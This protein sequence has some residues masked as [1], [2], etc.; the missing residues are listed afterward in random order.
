MKHS[1][2]QIKQLP[3]GYRMRCSVLR[4]ADG[5]DCTN[6]GLTSRV[7][8]GLIVGTDYPMFSAHADCPAFLLRER[9]VGN[10]TFLHVIPA[11]IPEGED[12][13]SGWMFG[14]NFL[15]C[16]DSRFPSPYPIPVHDRRE[17]FQPAQR[18]EW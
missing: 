7:R 8:Y 15:S 3:L 4:T 17:R 2:T 10:E 18:G 12:G 16:S 11:D 6:N 9:T 1:G 5:A 14:G 13:F